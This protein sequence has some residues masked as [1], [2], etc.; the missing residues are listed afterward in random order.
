MWKACC[1]IFALF[2]AAPSYSKESF[3]PKCSDDRGTNRCNSANQAKTREKYGVEDKETFAAKGTYLRRAMIV[4]GYGNDVLAVSFVRE[5]EKTPYVEIRIPRN[6]NG[7]ATK[8]IIAT[9]SNQEWQ[10][11]LEQGKFFDRELAPLKKSGEDQSICLHSWM[12][13]VETV[14]PS[15][16]SGNTMPEMVVGPELKSKIQS[17][18]AGGLAIDYA[19]QLVDLAYSMIPDCQSI[20]LEGHRN[21]AMVLNSCH[22]LSGDRIAAGEAMSLTRQ[23]EIAQYI[24]PK[25]LQ[26]TLQTLERLIAS[27]NDEPQLGGGSIS[28]AV[29]A[30]MVNILAEGNFHFDA[31]KGIDS[32]HAEIAA[33]QILNT[34]GDDADKW[35]KR[36]IMLFASKEAGDFRL[37]KITIAHSEMPEK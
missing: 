3:D 5:R 18:C 33:T 29:R 15:R 27:A 37:S 8:S 4:D 22:S 2:A 36:K 9:I 23:I 34:D 26:E 21:K 28:D 32:D 24:Y 11:V 19:F 6:E 7:K 31:I 13:N 12:V 14:N 17:A 25:N 20:P 30:E 16:L 35:P 1:L 10:S